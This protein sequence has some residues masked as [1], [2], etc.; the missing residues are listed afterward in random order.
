MNLQTAHNLH[1]VMRKLEVTVKNAH[2]RIEE[3]RREVNDETGSC[4]GSSSPAVAFGVCLRGIS[5]GMD[6]AADVE[7][8]KGLAGGR[9]FGKKFRA[10]ET[11]LLGNICEIV[12]FNHAASAAYLLSH[13]RYALILSCLVVHCLGLAKE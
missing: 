5:L 8:D 9:W 7:A 4:Q 10:T 3:P 13:A 1:K 2:V 12:L 11:A 6:E